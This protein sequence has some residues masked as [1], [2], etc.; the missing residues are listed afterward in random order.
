M[1]SA[2]RMKFK[3]LDSPL[4]GRVAPETKLKKPAWIDR[5]TMLPILLSFS[6]LFVFAL[7]RESEFPF[8]RTWDDVQEE[9]PKIAIIGTLR[10]C[11]Y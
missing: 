6:F 10:R 8:L 4:V 11:R 3:G 7:A 5:S 2:D 9:T 1:D